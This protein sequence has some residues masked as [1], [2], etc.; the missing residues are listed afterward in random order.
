M[1]NDKYNLT[2]AVLAGIKTQTRRLIA[3]GNINLIARHWNPKLNAPHC[4]YKDERGLCQLINDD[5]GEVLKPKYNIG[6]II[7]IAQNYKQCGYDP[8]LIQRGGNAKKGNIG[9]YPICNLAGW[10][11]KMFVIPELMP[12]RIK[13]TGISIERLQDI[14][15]EDCVREGLSMSWPIEISKK[16][17]EWKKEKQIGCSLEVEY[18]NSIKDAFAALYDKING[19]GTWQLNPLV[20]VYD[21]KLVD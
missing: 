20:W 10:K 12:H 1:F 7:A 15:D 16:Y 5:T 21:F 8:Y 2:D 19:K 6:E 11:N 9:D 3:K 13:I 14:S 4:Y 17:K 18:P